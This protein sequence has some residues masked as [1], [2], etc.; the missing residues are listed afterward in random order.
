MNKKSHIR[1][2]TLGNLI[3]VSMTGLMGAQANQDVVCPRFGA[4]RHDHRCQNLLLAGCAAEQ[5]DF[6]WSGGRRSII[7]EPKELGNSAC[8]RRSCSGNSALVPMMQAAH[9]R[10]GDDP[11]GFRRLDVARL[12][13]VLLQ[14]EVRASSV[15]IADE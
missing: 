10:D 4:A 8:D 14:C 2:V 9:L 15:I 3:G 13:R 1:N 11:S 6:L 12:W 5:P 7:T